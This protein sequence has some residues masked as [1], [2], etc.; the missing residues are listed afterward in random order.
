MVSNVPKWKYASHLAL[1]P[2]CPPTG[3]QPRERTAFRFVWNPID[4]SCFV[5]VAFRSGGPPQRVNRRNQPSC[6]AYGL[7][8]FTTE[9]LARARFARLEENNREIRK[10]IG[11]HLASVALTIAHG[12]QTLEASTGHFDLHEYEDANLVSAAVLVGT[13]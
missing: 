1:V 13:L 10:S 6:S 12:V 3:A 8:M 5:P 2:G 11:T 9:V 7:S 4:L